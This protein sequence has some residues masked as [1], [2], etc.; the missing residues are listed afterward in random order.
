M[1]VSSPREGNFIVFIYSLLNDAVSNS[2]YVHVA[3]NNKLE[4]M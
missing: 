1:E 3:V 2:D 4:G